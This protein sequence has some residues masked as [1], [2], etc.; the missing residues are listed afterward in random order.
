[1]LLVHTGKE[2][3]TP[4]AEVEVEAEPE[5]MNKIPSKELYVQQRKNSS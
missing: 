2:I 5:R 4:E 3:A 1:M